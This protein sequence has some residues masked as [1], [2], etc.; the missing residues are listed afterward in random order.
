MDDYR[1]NNCNV[2]ERNILLRFLRSTIIIIF[3]YAVYDVFNSDISDSLKSIVGLLVFGVC[4][5]LLKITD[6]SSLSKRIV[7]SVFMLSVGFGFFFQ[8]GLLGINSLDTIG[9]V[10]LI[11]LIFSG[12]ERQIFLFLL[13]LQLG[14]LGFIQVFYTELIVDYRTNDNLIFDLAEVLARVINMAYVCYLYK[15]EYEKE[16]AQLFEASERLRVVNAEVFSQNEIIAS[17]YNQLEIAMLRLNEEQ[18]QTLLTNRRLEEA[19]TEISTQ[20]EALAAYNRE[21]ELMVEDRMK[22][23]LILNKKLMEYSFINSHR[24]R[25]PLARVLGLVHL[26]KMSDGKVNDQNEYLDKLEISAVEMDNIVR[27]MTVVLNREMELR[28]EN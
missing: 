27:E 17:T 15:A 5:V 13:L 25:G 24:V 20:S 18:M 3:L 26:M 7:A 2:L 12:R 8:G 1:G 22:D 19:N 23:I 9:L 4:R 16:R 21:L 10:M 28:N 14:A 6:F 11:S